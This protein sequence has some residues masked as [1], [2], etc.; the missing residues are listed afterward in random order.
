MKVIQETSN[1]YRLTRFGMINCFLVKEEEQF[2]LVDT[3]LRGSA[4]QILKAAEQLG[5]PIARIVLTHAHLDHVGSVD[6]IKQSLPS[7][8]LFV[9]S[10]ESR[11]MR[12]DHSLA[13]N[14]QGKSL[15]GF[16]RVA[17]LPTR[18][19]TEGDRVGPLLV[20]N[21]PGH[22]PGHVAFLD[23]RDNSLIAGD[24]FTTQTGIIVAGVFSI[25]FPF[26]ALFSWNA[27]LAA[28]S[29]HKLRQLNPSRLCVGHGESKSSPASGMDRAIEIAYQQHPEAKQLM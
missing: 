1:L 23:V 22:T 16:P 10:R 8:E 9:G 3:G 12:G 28:C 6:A 25:I 29:A 2:I 5:L 18:L 11:I 14:E 26:P 20:V 24:A 7:V 4:S 21:S 13:K 17:S 27:S 15:F 19:L